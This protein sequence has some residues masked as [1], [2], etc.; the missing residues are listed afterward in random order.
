M[1][2]CCSC[3]D[4]NV[5][6]SVY[7]YMWSWMPCSSCLLKH[8]V[9][10]TMTG[11]NLQTDSLNR[12]GYSAIRITSDSVAHYA[13]SDSVHVSLSSDDYSRYN[14]C[15][16]YIGICNSVSCAIDSTLPTVLEPTVYCSQQWREPLR[17]GLFKLSSYI[18]I[19]GEKLHFY[20][21]TV[22]LRGFQSLTPFPL[23][24][25]VVYT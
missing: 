23:H 2:S 5:V 3:N 17:R 13:G 4:D 15:I 6:Y 10:A 11:I 21:R 16:T 1:L 7:M 18:C 19:Y 14:G 8:C 12:R 24:M 22:K 9:N 20:G 25:I